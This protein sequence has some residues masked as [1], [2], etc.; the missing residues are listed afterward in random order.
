MTFPT[1]QKYVSTGMLLNQRLSFTSL[2][3]VLSSYVAT[4]TTQAIARGFTRVG[5][6][7]GT[8]AALDGV[9]RWSPTAAVRGASTTTAQSWD[10]IQA[11]NGVQT[12]FFYTGGSADV[13]GI[14]CSPGGLYVLAG[15]PTF[16]PTAADEC[17]ATQ[18]QTLIGPTSSGDRIA[19][20]WIDSAHNGWRA[21]IFSASVLVGPLV[22][23]E[24]Y[25]PAF[26]LPP[27]VVTIPVWTGC[28]VPSSF[29]MG[30]IFGQYTA[31]A[32]GGQ[33]RITVSSVGTTV[34]FGA[35]GKV[36]G[37]SF[38]AENGFAQELNGTNFFIRAVGL[39]SITNGARGDVGNRFDFY[40]QQELKACGELDA[41]KSWLYMNN[42]SGVG[43]TVGVLWTWDGVSNW[44]GA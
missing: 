35:S 37:G 12:L 1:I 15:T 42:N 41:S 33:A 16:K 10:L 30:N 14:A 22:W 29:T 5:S 44:V 20:V 11:A 19:D 39:S 23:V 25:D 26:I 17:I 43:T 31:N 32:A 8:V 24:L 6:S 36:L 2:N 9:N 40:T 18:T 4:I 7:D 38:T 13:A 3:Q 28:L 21:A 27:A 34:N